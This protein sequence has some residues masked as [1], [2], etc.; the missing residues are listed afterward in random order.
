MKENMSIYNRP[1]QIVCSYNSAC[2]VHEKGVTRTPK[3]KHSINSSVQKE[4]GAS[5]RTEI[6]RP[7]LAAKVFLLVYCIFYRSIML[8]L[9][10]CTSAL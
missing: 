9:V 5:H 7:F 1:T 3:F 10:M 2:N 4:E 6:E 8:L